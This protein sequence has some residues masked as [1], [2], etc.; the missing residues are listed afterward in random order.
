M[1]QVALLASRISQVKLKLFI[2]RR[3]QIRPIYRDSTWDRMLLNPRIQDPMDR[4]GG[5]LFRKRFRV[6]FPMFEKILNIVREKAWFSERPDAT[7]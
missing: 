6:P 3:V 7:E 2:P 1:L 4:K 5:R